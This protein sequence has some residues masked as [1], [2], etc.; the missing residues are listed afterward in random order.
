VFSHLDVRAQTVGYVL[1]DHR[2]PTTSASLFAG[3]R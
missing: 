3:I 2:R 1:V